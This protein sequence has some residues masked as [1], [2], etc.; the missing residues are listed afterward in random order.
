MD[1]PVLGRHMN[2]Q[3]KHGTSDVHFVDRVV[4]GQP[5]LNTRWGQ[6]VGASATCAAACAVPRVN[7]AWGTK[8]SSYFM[9]GIDLQSQLLCLD[10]LAY[11]TR[12]D[13]QIAQIYAGIKQ[14][15]ENYTSDFLQVHAVDMQATYGVQ[16][17][18]KNLLDNGT[19]VFYPDITPDDGSDPN[20]AGMLTQ[21]NLG[22]ADLLPTSGLTFPLLDYH[23]AT[24]ALR[25][26][27]KAGSGLPSG[28]YNLL[29]DQRTWARMTNGNP[30]MKDMMA[31]TNPQQASPLYKINEGVVAPFGNY[32]A[33][34]NP[35]PI[36]FQHVGSGLL[37]RVYP[38]INQNADTGIEPVVNPAYINARYQISYLWHPK[39][40]KI[41]SKD[42][43]KIHEMVP[44]VNASM[45]GKWTFK[46]GDVLM[47]EQADGTVCTI[48]NDKNNQFYWV[49]ALELGFQYVEPQLLMPIL[50]LTDGS[51]KDSIVDDVIC[52]T[53]PQYTVQN[54]SDNPLVC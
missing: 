11:S 36:R 6:K 7:V 2:G 10:Q 53:A 20:I 18:S 44:S 13:E 3:W 17:A 39:A 5:N 8:R 48:N 51:G 14:I 21:M 27:N 41:W 23:A 33:T 42:M 54:Y 15:P 30:S 24:L 50:H 1:S 4:V 29:T 46:N 45:Y 26:Y 9:E 19:N 52:G 35:I 40:I 47:Y 38:F 32:A 34:L 28:M 25:G 12:P 16:I 49:C 43:S 22:S 37:E 31:L